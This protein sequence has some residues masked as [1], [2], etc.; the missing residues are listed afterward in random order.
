MQLIDL[1]QYTTH[2]GRANYQKFSPKVHWAL[3]A[4]SDGQ[5]KSAEHTFLSALLE[6]EALMTKLP[7]GTSQHEDIQ[8][9]LL[10]LL[11]TESEETKIAAQAIGRWPLHA[12]MIIAENLFPEL[13]TDEEKYDTVDLRLDDYMEQFCHIEESMMCCHPHGTQHTSADK[14]IAQDWRFILTQIQEAI[15]DVNGRRD[16]DKV[17][18]VYA[19]YRP[20]KL[21]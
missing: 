1:S 16:P 19:G 15:A 3:A 14:L 6:I 5:A 4:K 13:T 8:N 9:Y 2:T 21:C 7:F 11:E 18:D 12:C 17:F 20:S 10:L